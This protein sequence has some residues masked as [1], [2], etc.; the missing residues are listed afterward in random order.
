MKK[1]KTMVAQVKEYIAYKRNLGF[2]LCKDAGRLL[3]F[4]KYADESGHTGP[5][6]IELVLKWA[7]LPKKASQ[8]NPAYRVGIVRCFAKYQAIFFSKTE[9][10]PLRILGPGYRRTEPYIYSQQQISALLEACIQLTPVD[11]LRPRTYATLFGLLAC[12]GLRISEALKLSRD[13][14]DLANG[15]M[16]IAETKFHKSRL[17]PLDPTASKALSEYT[18]FRDQHHPIVKSKK[19]FLSE[20]GFSL[21]YYAVHHAFLVLRKK[22]GWYTKKKRPRITDFRHTFACRRLLL[23]YEQGVDINHAIYS[24]STYLGHVKVS[25]TYWYLTGV[26]ELFAI[27]V[28]KFEKFALRKG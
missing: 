23:W 16:L 19:F 12:T 21:S 14:V 10:P 15:V 2:Q 4:A 20:K 13:D 5:V 22:L 3:N 17:V 6:T 1:Q 25:N 7:R 9:I 18:K 27:A 24:L 8:S 11:G 26:P 28:K